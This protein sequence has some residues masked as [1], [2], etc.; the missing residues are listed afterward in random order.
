M[1]KENIIFFSLS[2]GRRIKQYRWTKLPMPSEVITRI[3]QLA[4][5][6]C[7]NVDEDIANSK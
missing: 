5:G 3:N 4:S 7:Y 2:T 1:L 6:D